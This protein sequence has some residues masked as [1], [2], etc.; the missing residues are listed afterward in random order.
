MVIGGLPALGLTLFLPIA[1]Y[2]LIVHGCDYW[3][4]LKSEELSTKSWEEQRAER[5]YK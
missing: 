1:F 4:R 2:A 3:S 5:K